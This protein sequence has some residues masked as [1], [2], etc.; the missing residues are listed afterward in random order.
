MNP[1]R[2]IAVEGDDIIN[3]N[4]YLFSWGALATVVY[5]AG[6]LLEEVTG[7][8]VRQ[9]AGNNRKAG[10][11]YG[12]TATSMIVMVSSVRIFV[13][14]ECSADTW[15]STEYCKRTKFGISLGVLSF[16]L[17]FFVAYYSARGVMSR[18]IEL[19]VTTVLLTMW[20]FGVGFITFGR[21]PGAKIGNL[22]LSTWASFILIVFLFA[23][24]FRSVMS[25]PAPEP[26]D[27]KDEEHFADAG[28][29]EMP[30]HS[31][32]EVPGEDDI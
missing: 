27:N 26:D 9:V 24:T 4:L 17:A 13:A 16:V 21:S 12:L 15:S 19:G 25:G 31:A 22:Y 8:S 20:C 32:P 2:G 28:E 7:V 5:I 18:M 6:S 11:W 30:H 14:K 1:E 3:A 29:Q 10:R 23:E